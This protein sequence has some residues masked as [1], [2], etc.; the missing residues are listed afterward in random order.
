MD[1]AI[2][3]LPPHLTP[4]L[5]MTR[6]Q[7]LGRASTGIGSAALAMLLA[8]TARAQPS[9]PLSRGLETRGSRSAST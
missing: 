9:P 5:G 3:Q 1:H 2:S 6:R 8:D 7:F 4:H